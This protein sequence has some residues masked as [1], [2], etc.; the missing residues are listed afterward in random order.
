MSYISE[1]ALAIKTEQFILLKNGKFKNKKEVKSMLSTATIYSRKGDNMFPDSTLV[2][3]KSVH[4]NY[5][6][7]LKFQ[8]SLK[9]LSEDDY[10][11]IEI[12]DDDNHNEFKGDWQ[13]NPFMLQ[14]RRSIY[15]ELG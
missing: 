14:L 9:S 1:I 11:L 13:D 8:D 15:M 5:P 10:Y 12:G 7:A 4:W 6:E 2:H 3:W